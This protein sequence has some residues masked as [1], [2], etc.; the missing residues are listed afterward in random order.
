MPQLAV[1]PRHPSAATT[2]FTAVTRHG[3]R[4]S[5][6][7]ARTGSGCLLASLAGC[8][9][10]LAATVEAGSPLGA[11][12]G[13]QEFQLPLLPVHSSGRFLRQCAWHRKCY[14]RTADRANAWIAT[15]AQCRAQ[16][17]T[18]RLQV[19]S[20]KGEG[21]SAVEGLRREDETGISAR[22][23]E[24]RPEYG[25]IGPR[26]LRG[27]PFTRTGASTSLRC[28]CHLFAG[29]CSAHGG[30]G[31]FL[32]ACSRDLGEGVCTRPRRSHGA[33]CGASSCCGTHALHPGTCS[34]RA[35]YDPEYQIGGHGGSWCP[36]SCGGSLPGGGSRGGAG[37]E[38]HTPWHC[39]LQCGKTTGVGGPSSSAGPEASG[40]ARCQR[41][42]PA[43]FCRA[44]EEQHQGC[45]QRASAT[46]CLRPDPKREVGD[47]TCCRV[48]R[49]C[50]A[51]LWR[52]GA[53]CS[54]Y[55]YNTS[56]FYCR[57]RQRPRRGSGC[58]AGASAGSL[59]SSIDEGCYARMEIARNFEWLRSPMPSE[60]PCL[61]GKTCDSRRRVLLPGQVQLRVGLL[62]CRERA[63]SS[64]LYIGRLC[65]L[66]GGSGLV[67][68]IPPP[69]PTTQR[70]TFGA[71]PGLF[72][73]LAGPF[74]GTPCCPF[75]CPA[76]GFPSC[77]F[78]WPSYWPFS[79]EPKRVAA[80]VRNNCIGR[81]GTVTPLCF[82]FG[83]ACTEGF[84]MPSTH[85]CSGISTVCSYMHP[86][87]FE[88]GG[89]SADVLVM[90][91][92][93]CSPCCVFPNASAATQPFYGTFGQFLHTGSGE[94][95]SDAS[96]AQG[97]PPPPP[98]TFGQLV[99]RLL[100]GLGSFIVPLA[101]SMLL[102]FFLAILRL[103]SSSRAPLPRRLFAL[104]LCGIDPQVCAPLAQIGSSIAQDLR[105]SASHK[106]G[107]RDAARGRWRAGF[108][109]WR[110]G[111]SF[112]GFLM[113][114]SIPSSCPCVVP[115]AC[116]LLLATPADAMA[117]AEGPED[118]VP[119][120]LAPPPPPPVLEPSVGVC[121]V[122]IP[123]SDPDHGTPAVQGPALAC[124]RG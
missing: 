112:L 72:L 76:S 103:G 102:L 24:I 114:H 96:V 64:I 88:T 11:R 25:A 49:A 122:A 124:C 59:T 98:Y 48:P 23:E 89:C 18:A 28:A 1:A 2:S 80:G 35:G 68:P 5:C 62:P 54:C 14:P 120:R 107:R 55:G 47:E 8:L 87:L 70:W 113:P 63:A 3:A 75:V 77:S 58:R 86:T 44:T 10:T 79:A 108:R 69:S 99:L 111:W 100:Q 109:F 31:H 60:S 46:G 74:P 38:F 20:A 118:L 106:P 97:H 6:F 90:V 95:L 71:Y 4:R 50:D 53:S 15:A 42:T 19:T 13:Q 101:R 45:D 94:S 51:P 65:F 36:C 119:S 116:W 57:R 34:T 30:R 91:P 115:C 7:Q 9:F 82:A 61:L 117:R 41:S 17:G 121:D 12:V 37:S 52:G 66:P 84:L 33:C 22:K 56:S 105:R 85:A 67:L 93:P 123:W 40:A 83:A 92:R 39:P 104:L 81:S 27:A 29:H 16:S 21:A 73:G 32:G 110:F 78:S 26:D 43:N